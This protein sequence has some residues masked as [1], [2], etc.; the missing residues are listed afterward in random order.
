MQSAHDSSVAAEIRG[1]DGVDLSYQYRTY[2]FL[3]KYAWSSEVR[4]RFMMSGDG[5][6]HAEYS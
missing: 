5:R 2:I 4:S 1:P 6:S 3:F